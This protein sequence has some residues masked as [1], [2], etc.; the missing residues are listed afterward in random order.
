MKN[1]FGQSLTVTLFGESHGEEI[2]AVLDGLAPGIPVDEEAIRARLALRRPAGRISTARREPDEF[3]IVSGVFRQRTTGTPLCILIPNTAAH[4]ADYEAAR[5]LARPGHADYTAYR[6]YHG[7][8]DYRGGGHFSGRLTAALTAAGAIVLSAL[9][10]R[11]VRIGTHVL[12]CAGIPDRPFGDIAADLTA[13]EGRA[14]GVLDETAGERMIRGI[15]AAAEAGDSVGG[16]TETAILGL[17]AGVGEPWFDSLESTLSHMLFSIPAVKGVQFGDGFALAEMRGSEA[18]DPFRME[19]GRVVTV[20]N[21]N[22]GVNG[23]ISNGM[24]VLLRCAVKPTP[25]IFREQQTVDFVRGE[26]AALTLTGRHDPAVVHRARAVID[27]A[28]ALAVADAL[29]VRYGTDALARGWEKDGG[30]E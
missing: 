9:A 19:D 5:A 15:E 16:V 8:E 14:F 6:K 27:C 26:N 2:G 4:S 10:A 7:Y 20:S 3:R 13:L 30:A 25:S 24:P 17:P 11:G 28:A 1:T 21:H 18:N 12:R 29:A 23:G 22:G